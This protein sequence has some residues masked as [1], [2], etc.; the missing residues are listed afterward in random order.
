VATPTWTVRS[1]TDA[2]RDFLFELHRA[3][4]RPSVEA[5][6]GWDE[7]EQVAF[8]DAR[9]DPDRRRIVQVDGVDIGE[10]VVDERP[11]E[12]YLARLALLP[13]WQGRGIGASIVRSLLARA[14]ATAKP[15]VLQ[16]LHT[17]PRAAQLYERLGFRRNGRS[18]THVFM[19][20]ELLPPPDGRG[21]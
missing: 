16:V 7:D 17:N 2:D 12:I 21:H 19:R 6:W 10:L 1:A 5:M 18:E 8:F 9:F 3:A 15:V 20:A 4:F 13:M 14:E 11:D